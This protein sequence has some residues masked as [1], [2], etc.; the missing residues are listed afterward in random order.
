MSIGYG[1]GAPH[2]RTRQMGERRFWVA[3]L[4]AMS[5]VLW[6][7]SGGSGGTAAD[8]AG[9]DVFVAEGGRAS[10]GPAMDASQPDVNAPETG[11]PDSNPPDSRVADSTTPDSSIPD[12]SIPDSAV[13]DT[14]KPET[15]TETGTG[16]FTVGGTV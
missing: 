7:C 4:S 6:G 13:A 12:S 15:S 9:G 8:D 5:L 14:S 1:T 10:D 3:L 2:S 16:R 11:I